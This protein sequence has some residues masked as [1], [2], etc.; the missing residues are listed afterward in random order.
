MGRT[1]PTSST[2]EG[3]E[4]RKTGEAWTQ[5]LLAVIVTPFPGPPVQP[6]ASLQRVSESIYWAAGPAS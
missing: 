3:G 2:G 5:F 4:V 1:Y 6:A